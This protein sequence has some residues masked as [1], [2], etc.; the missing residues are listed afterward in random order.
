[1]SLKTLCSQ[2]AKK[3]LALDVMLLFEK[4]AT[5]LHPLCDLLDHWK[6]E[7]DQGE[8]QPVYEEF[9]SVLLLLLAFVHR[10]GLSTAEIGVKSPDSFVAKL[11]YQSSLSRPSDDLSD[12]EKS[13][14]DGW[15]RG[16]FDQEAGGLTDDLIS[17]CPP[18]DFYLLVPTLFQNIVMAF[19]AGYLTEEGL[20]SGVE[21]MCIPTLLGLCLGGRGPGLTHPVQILSTLSSFRPSSWRLPT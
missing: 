4:P 14:L 18:Q 8:Y 9:G 21:C 20:K 6:Y 17:S 16:L 19:G 5:I 1:M 10:Y 3:P 11:L 2:L 15:I 12:Q 13:H 7:E